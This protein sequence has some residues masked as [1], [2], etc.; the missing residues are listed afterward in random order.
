MIQFFSSQRGAMFGLDA[1][2]ALAVFAIIGMVAGA[3]MVLD[4]DSTRAK[5]LASELTDTARAIESFHNDL[6]NDIFLVLSQP[7]EK[8]A[9]Q[10]LYDNSVITEDNNYRSRWNGPYIR[11]TSNL[12]TSYGEM[13]LQKHGADHTQ[14]CAQD[15]TCYLWLVYNKVKPAVVDEANNLLDGNNEPDPSHSGRIQWSQSED[16]ARMLYFRATRALSS[17]LE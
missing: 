3:A 14:A 16:N 13:L 5:S 4:M 17:A 6:K 15:E 7:S 12:H 10:A 1:R 8:D 2:I 9:F 11:F